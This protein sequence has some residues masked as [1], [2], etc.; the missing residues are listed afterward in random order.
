MFYNSARPL[1]YLFVVT[2]QSGF[3][4]SKS[5]RPL[6]SVFVILSS[7]STSLP[8]LW[9]AIQP[10]SSL[11]CG[12]QISQSLPFPFCDSKFSQASP[13]PFCDF[14][15]SQANPSL[16]VFYNSASPSL[17][18]LWFTIQSVPSLF[19]ISNSVSPSLP[20]CG[21]QFSQA[22]SFHFCGLQSH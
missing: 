2:I 12:F 17:P 20:F 19:V 4:I 1:P 10:G 5:A 3:V 9:F 22:S 8:F 11:F 21:L 14:Q 18:F 13:F 6:P 16:F 7:T 15:F